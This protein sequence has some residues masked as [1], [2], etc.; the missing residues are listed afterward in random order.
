MWKDYKDRGN[1]CVSYE[2]Y[3]K[4][5]D[6]EGIT[7]GQPSTDDCDVCTV[8][9]VHV[10]DKGEC[11]D[12]NCSICS[13]A[14]SH[15]ARVKA[16]RDEY[17]RDTSDPKSCIFA[18]DMQ[19]IIL[20]PKL[21]TKEHFFVS[22]LIVFNETFASVGGTKPDYVI[23]WHEE[24]AGR[25]ASDVANSYIKC[26]VLCASDDVTFWCDNCS[27]QNKNWTLF[28]AL[29]TVVNSDWGPSCVRIKYLER[30][31][32]FMRAD[33]VHGLI[34]KRM[35]KSP[36]VYNFDDFVSLCGKAGKSIEPVVLHYSD[37][38][39]FAAKNR[40]RNCKTVKLPLLSAISEVEFRKGSRNLF[41]KKEFSDEFTSADFLSPKF[42]LR[43]PE[44]H[45]KPRGI[46]SKKKDG[47]VKLLESVP[48]AKRKFWH[49]LSVNEAVQDLA[50]N[51]TVTV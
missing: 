45:T 19:K 28:T 31:H 12:E 33:S 15:L 22:R 23:L 9:E 18:C 26:I 24:V 44:K 21:S 32:T 29:I 43:L 36:E 46:P 5:F 41:Y 17:Q 37:F 39:S 13:N 2:T 16:A 8:Y 10:K 27:G 30:G 6:E 50:E 51:L 1:P 7:F 3:R 14:K 35:S 20:L 40:T 42:D 11:A 49:E 38:Y 47:L 25:L 34:G 4:I 48:A